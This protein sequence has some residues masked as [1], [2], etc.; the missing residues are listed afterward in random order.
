MGPPGWKRR[1]RRMS[2]EDSPSSPSSSSSSHG[3]ARLLRFLVFN[4]TFGPREGEEEK[5]IVFYHPAEDAASKRAQNVGFA[6]ACVNFCRVFA[7]PGTRRGDGDDV[8]DEEEEE[9]EE[10]GRC[11]VVRTQKTKTAF[12]KA[13]GEFVLS[14]TVA[15]PFVAAKRKRS[16]RAASPEASSA[17][18]SLEYFSDD[19]F[20]GVL[21]SCL[22][23]AYDA[24]RFFG[25]AASF[26]HALLC[27]CAGDPSALRGVVDAFFARFVA[28]LRQRV[29][30]RPA[31]ALADVFRPLQFLTLEQR[32]FLRTQCFCGQ[33]LDE[34]PQVSRVVFLQQGNVVWTDLQQEDTRLLYHYVAS[35]LLPSVLP[36]SSSSAAAGGGAG[37][38]NVL[39]PV[40]PPRN[41]FSGHRGRFLAGGPP[42]LQGDISGME[43]KTPTVRLLHEAT[44]DA[45]QEDDGSEEGGEKELDDPSTRAEH[46]LLVYHAVAAT[47]C[48]LVPAFHDDLPDEFFRQFDA[49]VGPR[50]T[51]LS[52]D[53]L[54][55][56]GTGGSGGGG[57]SGL[58]PSPSA[59]SLSHAQQ[60]GLLPHSASTSVLCSP[61]GPDRSLGWQE[62]SLASPAP[63]NARYFYFNG[64][65]L[66]MKSTLE[67]D[68][69]AADAFAPAVSAEMGKVLLDLAEHFKDRCDSEVGPLECCS[70]T[71]GD[72]WAV[73]KLSAGRVVLASVAA[74]CSTL[75]DASEEVDRLIA[76]DFKNVFLLQN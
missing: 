37:G 30:R 72:Q 75:M 2:S 12:L 15:L 28:T 40:A 8:E 56:F 4:S 54:D 10:E 31:P 35:A 26:R 61:A 36:G 14:M 45:T 43:W 41:P 44:P 46:Q 49:A 13:E 59:S 33:L 62:F 76:H 5:K 71:Y 21:T 22:E 24:F 19:V 3:G 1:R 48:L 51:N 74:K 55:V 64:A 53:L 29:E 70:K 20:D 16:G 52:A 67:S 58:R 32:D 9:E 65:N 42:S 23:H 25:P 60:E 68:G 6:E 34:F 69:A 38:G 73:G 66:A 7:G 47:L 39:S 18:P 27:L 63:P 50:L 17:T 11:R 57:G